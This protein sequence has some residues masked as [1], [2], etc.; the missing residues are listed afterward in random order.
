M[1]GDHSYV[2]LSKCVC[3]CVSV[4]VY[5]CRGESESGYVGSKHNSIWRDAVRDGVN[6]ILLRA[7]SLP[8]SSF[9][10]LR[11]CMNHCGCVC[12]TV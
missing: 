8:P 5:E 7:L 12:M 9:R 3:E 10:F 2:R 4:F 11:M 1:C 6:R